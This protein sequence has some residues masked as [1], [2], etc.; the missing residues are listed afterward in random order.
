MVVPLICLLFAVGAHAPIVPKVPRLSHLQ[1]G[2]KKTLG[3]LYF[4]FFGQAKAD[5]DGNLFFHPGVPNF[6]NSTIVEIPKDDSQ[7]IVYSLAPEFAKTT[8]FEGFDVSPEGSVYVLAADNTDKRQFI[9]GFNSDG[10]V[11]DNKELQIPPS[12]KITN[13]SVFESGRIAVFGSRASTAPAT[14]SGPFLAIF[15]GAGTM[16]RDMSGRLPSVKLVNHDSLSIQEGDS[17]L[18]TDG[19]VYF[20]SSNLIFGVGENGRIARAV[21]FPKPDKTTPVK[22]VASDGLAAIWLSRTETGSNDIDLLLETVDLGSKKPAGL[23]EPSEELGNVAVNFSRSE[24]FLF[25]KALDQ[26]MQLLTA[27]LP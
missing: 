20:L 1:V 17:V 25:L 18:G 15:D 21:P 8:F 16:I 19:K 22:I 13:F 5:G 12:V 7:P 10:S 27:P 3:S 24:G 11:R 23:Y 26:H 9:F 4:S 2:T 6:R 14:P